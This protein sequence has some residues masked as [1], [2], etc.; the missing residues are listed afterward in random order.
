[1]QCLSCAFPGIPPFSSPQVGLA[2]EDKEIAWCKCGKEMIWLENGGSSSGQ[3]IF[4]K[5][6][7][8]RRRSEK[9]KR[10]CN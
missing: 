5:E 3:G 2:G 10:N 1:M 9:G 7:E 6:E 8:R 4:R